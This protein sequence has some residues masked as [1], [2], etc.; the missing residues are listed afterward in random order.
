MPHLASS[1]RAAGGAGD[2]AVTFVDTPKVTTP[3]DPVA[4][5]AVTFY[6][7]VIQGRFDRAYDLSVEPRWVGP[8]LS[9]LTSRWDFV[10][11]LREEIGPDGLPVGIAALTVDWERPFTAAPTVS[12]DVPELAALHLLPRVSRLA[13]AHVSGQLVGNCAIGAFSRTDVLGEVGGEWKVLLPGRAAAAGPHFE[14]WFLPRSG[15]LGE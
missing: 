2:N 11:S 6:R 13:L 9:G 3:T 1:A 10:N 8:R 5:A 4:R 14:N 7:S 15:A 12:S